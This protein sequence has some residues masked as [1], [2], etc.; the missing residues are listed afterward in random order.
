MVYYYN[1]NKPDISE[2]ILI[3]YVTNMKLLDKKS[4]LKNAEI[5]GSIMPF[6]TVT[7]YVLRVHYTRYYGTVLIEGFLDIN[8]DKLKTFIRN[9]KLQ[10]FIS[11]D[12]TSF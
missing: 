1:E 7:T 12:P 3:E 5:H 8:V 2:D 6:D 4:K 9:K 10:K 11:S